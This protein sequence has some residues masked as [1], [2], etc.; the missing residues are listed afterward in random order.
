MCKTLRLV[1]CE[2]VRLGLCVKQPQKQGPDRDAALPMKDEYVAKLK[3]AA[4]VEDEKYRGMNEV[5]CPKQTKKMF[6]RS[7]SYLFILY[8]VLYTEFSGI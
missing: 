2:D 4:G 8:R 6:V 7:E 3:E 1:V 5:K